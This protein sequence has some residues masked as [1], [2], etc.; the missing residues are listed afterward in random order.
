MRGLLI[1]STDIMSSIVLDPLS[2]YFTTTNNESE[3][4]FDL[5][6]G[7]RYLSYTS[8]SLLS[9]PFEFFSESI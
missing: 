4:I 3:I 7:L 9:A 5:S 6:S 1:Q 8:D 2:Y